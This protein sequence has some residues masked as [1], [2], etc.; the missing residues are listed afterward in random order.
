[1]YIL[2]RFLDDVCHKKTQKQTQKLDDLSFFYILPYRNVATVRQIFGI[3][4]IYV[5]SLP[6]F[7]KL[8]NN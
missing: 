3:V 8:S 6:D 5:L 1:M 2:G 7:K 4:K